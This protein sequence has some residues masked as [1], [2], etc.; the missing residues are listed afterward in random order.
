V[1][2][3]VPAGLRAFVEIFPMTKPAVRRR[4]RAPTSTSTTALSVNSATLRFATVPIAELKLPARKL[5]RHP[6]RLKAALQAALQQFGFTRPILVH[7]T[8]EIIAGAAVF[9]AAKQLN[10]ASVPVIYAEHLSKEQVRLYRIADNQLATMSSF[11]E[12]TLRLEF[13]D[14]GLAPT[15]DF[16]V[17]LG[18]LGFPDGK[19]DSIL[20]RQ[21]ATSDDAGLADDETA[22]DLEPAAGPAVTRS[23]DI[24]LIGDHM[25]L[26]GNSLEK[27]SYDTF[28]GEERAQIVIV[29]GPYNVP[30]QGHVSGRK[31]AREFAF[32]SGEMSSEEFICFERTV[33]G[34]LTQ[35]SLDGS[36]QYHFMS[37]HWL[38]ELLVA[39]KVEY[40]ELKNILVW[41]KTNCSR[42]FYRSQHELICVFKNGT[43]PHICTFGLEKGARWRSN[44]MTYAGCNSFGSTRD[45]DLADH[46]TV[47]PLPLIAD[48]LRDCSH[49]FGLVLDPFGGSGTT[50][51]AAEWTRRRARLIEIDPAYVDV[52]INRARKR[53]GLEA[54]LKATGQSFA[55]VAAERLGADGEVSDAEA[56]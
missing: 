4:E 3:V 48:L 11:N 1:P 49:P 27:G 18:V 31:D 41:Q 52:T 22:E 10:Y 32:A 7:Q 26:C 33:M 40:D 13:L 54:V 37:W 17:D 42:G 50:L 20:L 44:V 46:P 55:E 47:K 14:L 16:T 12:D 28:L 24:W 23:G 39:G 8:G 25:I 34:H 19:I 9:E 38:S 43:A 51:L 6:K 15:S 2:F 56:A 53:F 21:P 36:I 45:E 35:F 29:D 5:R 30:V